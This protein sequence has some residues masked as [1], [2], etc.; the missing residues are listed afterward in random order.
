M[1]DTVIRGGTIVD[2]TGSAGL[3]RRR[4]HRRRP[5]RPGRR[6]GRA[7][8]ARDQGRRPAGHARLGRRPHPLR[9]P[10]DLGP[11]CWR[12][13]RGTA[14]PPSCSAI[15]ASASP[16]C[17]ASTISALIG[18]M[19]AVE[20]IPGITLTEG[21]KWDWESFPEYLDA[22]D[23]ACRA[24]ST[25]PRRSPHHPLRVYVMGERAI[26]RE[27][28]TAEDIDAMRRLTRG[29]AGGRRLRLHHLAHRPAQDA[30]RRDGARPLF[31]G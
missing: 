30:D 16:R 20:D 27:P 29:G 28:A 12:R 22:L 6:Q 13:H 26:D 9:R 24:R 14:S 2:G 17:A 11:G 21:L 3:H 5:H 25:S 4:R 19:E 18:L 15:A 23:A 7:R 8:Q 31:R 10:G 1:H